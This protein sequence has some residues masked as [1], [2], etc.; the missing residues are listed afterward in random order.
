[1]G[2]SQILRILKGLPGN[3]NHL[4]LLSHTD[5]HLIRKWAVAN[6]FSIRNERYVED[7]ELVYL[8]LDM[9]RVSSPEFGTSLDHIFG[10]EE[11][12]NGYQRKLFE[13]YW[14]RNGKRICKIPAR[15]RDGVER[16]V[17]DFLRKEG[18]V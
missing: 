7:G 17:I 4:I 12:R 16:E 1:M 18:I 8:I 5:Y 14:R 9:I 10:R 6:L 13:K 11:F 3:I 15:F 2:T